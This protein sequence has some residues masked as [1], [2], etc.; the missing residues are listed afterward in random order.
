MGPKKVA[1]NPFG[2]TSKPEK[3]KEGSAIYENVF[4]YK[5]RKNHI[6]GDPRKRKD[7]TYLMKW[8]KYVKLQRAKS[9]LKKRLKVPPAINQFNHTLDLNT[10]HALF[11]FLHKYRPEAKIDKKKR[12]AEAAKAAASDKKPKQEPKKP[13]YVKHG[14]NHVVGLIEQKKANLVVIAHDVDPIELVVYL[15]ALCRKMGVPY[16]IVKSRSRLGTVVHLDTAAVL[17]VTEVRKEDEKELATLVSAAKANFTDKYEEHRR[18]WG[19]GIM[20]RKTVRK[21]KAREEA[22]KAAEIAPV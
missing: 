19:G 4:S 9:V 15:P 21:L 7:T 14:L 3:K 17:A 16:V 2:S 1:A 6:G 8:P 20:G 11:K 13:L 5:S 12:L 18:R 22:I 10:A